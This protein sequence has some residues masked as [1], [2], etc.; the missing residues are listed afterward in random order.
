M[1]KAIPFFAVFGLCFVLSG[2][3]D[4]FQHITKDNN[5]IDKN[6]IK[7]TVSKTVFAMANGLSGSGNNRVVQ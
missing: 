3:I 6:T 5:G 4:I 7:V 1:K 2:C